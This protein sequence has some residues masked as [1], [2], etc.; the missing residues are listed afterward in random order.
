MSTERII[1][2]GE[3]RTAGPKG[4]ARRVRVAGMLPAVVYGQYREPIS[5]AVAPKDVRAILGTTYGFNS[6]FHLHID[7]QEPV[8]CMIKA[9]QIDPVRRILTHVDFYA[10]SEDHAVTIDVPVEAVGTSA[11][12]KAGGRLQIVSRTVK[13]KCAVSDI[14]ATIP[15]D[16]TPVMIGD[17]VY[18]DEMTPPQGCTFVYKNRFPV[19]RIA[20]KR[21]A[22]VA[23]T[24]TAAAPAAT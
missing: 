16:V 2:K 10:V 19:I 17:A 1:L 14:P 18:V 13:V 12:V 15:H 21:G 5:I 3:Q 4:F 20:R 22:K 11:G 7:G 6:V 8:M 9:W 24:E 23:A